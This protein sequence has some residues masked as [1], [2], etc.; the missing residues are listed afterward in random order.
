[1]SFPLRAAGIDC[2]CI[3]VGLT[4]PMLRID[5]SNVL[6]RPKSSNFPIFITIIIK[7][8]ILMILLVFI[9]ITTRIINFLNI[10]ITLEVKK[11]S[12]HVLA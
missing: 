3:G 8:T 9:Q 10:R 7:M 2:S 1:M 5:F 12:Q 11:I 4:K 6:E